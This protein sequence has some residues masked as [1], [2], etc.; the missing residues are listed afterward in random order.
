MTDLIYKPNGRAGEYAELALNIYRGCDHG[1]SYCYAPDVLHVEREAF[2]HPAPRSGDFFAKL[3]KEAAALGHAPVSTSLFDTTPPVA[4]GGKVTPKQVLLCFT[5][6]PYCHLDVEL[7]HTRRVIEILHRHGLTINVLTKGGRRA[8]RDIDLFTPQDTFGTTL[9]FMNPLK[10]LK[11]EPHAELPA[12]RI[13][14]LQAVHMR[15]IP[16]W[17]SLEPVLI[18][19][20][21]L[22]IIRTCHAFV[23]FWKV[24]TLN[25]HAHATTVN[26]YTFARN[27]VSLLDEIGAKYLIKD[28]LKKHLP[29]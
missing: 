14:T 5:T 20:E 17:V 13:E 16:T 29:A 23:D 26:W 11:W 1:C 27:V 24:G 10:S 7:Q 3:E 4:R 15:G 28:D 2:C 9:T 6:D 25:H 12:D 21:T 19:A 22:E 8:L 18:A